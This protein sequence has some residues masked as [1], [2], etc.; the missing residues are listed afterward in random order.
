M[1]TRKLIL[2]AFIAALLNSCGLARP[3]AL[4]PG[5]YQV[6]KVT[7]Q[8][9]KAKVYLTGVE[10]P[11]YTIADTLKAGDSITVLTIKPNR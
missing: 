6:T 9:N 1:N 3:A 4:Q 11:L 7:Y 8:R 2:A 10:R 5:R